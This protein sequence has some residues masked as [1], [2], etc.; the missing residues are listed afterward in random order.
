M[1]I[2]QSD[3]SSASLQLAYNSQIPPI[4]VVYNPKYTIVSQLSDR[5][6]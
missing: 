2:Q 1:I 6:Q 3:E 5:A 4:A